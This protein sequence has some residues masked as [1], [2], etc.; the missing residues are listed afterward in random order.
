MTVNAFHEEAVLWSS[1][2]KFTLFEL[3]F[4]KNL[5][6]SYAFEPKTANSFLLLQEFKSQTEKLYDENL[7]LQKQIKKH[8]NELGG[9]FE[10]SETHFDRQS[11]IEHSQLKSIIEKHIL[12]FTSLKTEIFDSVSYTHLTLPTICSV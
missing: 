1:K 12:N 10:C 9:F 2:L 11:N 3:N 5:I 8:E 7:R 4:A 6:S